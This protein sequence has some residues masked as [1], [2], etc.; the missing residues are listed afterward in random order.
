MVRQFKTVFK[1]PA[2]YTAMKVFIGGGVLL[3]AGNGEKV[4][5]KGDV[6]L[7]LGKPC[8]RDR[9]LVAV[10]ASLD[11][12]I[13]R[14]VADRTGALGQSAIVIARRSREDGTV[15]GSSVHGLAHHPVGMD[16]IEL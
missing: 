8:D 12:V 11:D 10:I 6:E 16:G 3:L 4:G 9:N 2:G 14:P 15:L 7:V 13:G 1:R 5:L